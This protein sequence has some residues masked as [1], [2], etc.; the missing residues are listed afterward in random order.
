MLIYAQGGRLGNDLGGVVI[1]S[2]FVDQGLVETG[3]R[4]CLV[5]FRGDLHVIG[6]Y[7][8]P[9][10]RF[11][12]DEG[13]WRISG[14]RPPSARLAVSVGAGTGGSDGLCLAAIKFLHK[15]GSI[16]LAES[17]FGNVVNVGE[18]GGA[19]RSWSGIDAASGE[20]RVTHVRG[21]VS[22]D[23]AE[24]R[25]AWE[26]PYGI[27]AY[28][29]NV[30]T[31][32]LTY[33][34]KG[35]DHGLVPETRF[36][37]EW[38]G[39]MWYASAPKHPYRI[40]YSMAGNPQYV[41]PAA[42]RDTLG[43]EEITGIAKGRNELIV[44]C[45]RNS[46]MIRQFGS[47]VNDF[48]MEKLDS[49]V[50]CIS[51]FG[52]LE[53]HNKLWFPS[54]DGVWLYDGGFRYLMREVQP[55]WRS[56]WNSNKEDFLA[57]FAL[58]DRINKV[59]LWVTRRP[60]REEFENTGLAPGTV[61]Y[62]GYY[63]AFEPSMAG[64]QGHPEWSLDMKY[65][66]DSAGFYDTDGNLVI[67]SCDGKI[68]KQDWTDG[69]DDDDLLR[70]ELL[71]RSGHQ[72]FFEPGDDRESGKQVTQLWFYV[73]SELTSWSLYVRGGDEEAWRSALPDNDLSFWKISV[74]DSRKEE[75]R[76]IRRARS[77]KQ[78]LRFL[79][80]PATVH[81]FVPEQCVG[82]G[83]TFETRAVAPIGLEYRGFGGVWLPGATA[84]GV[85]QMTNLSASV[86]IHG[87]GGNASADLEDDPV[88]IGADLHE[89]VT[90]DPTVTLVYNY[91]SA[92]WPITLRL[93]GTGDQAIDD[94]LVLQTPNLTGS[95]ATIS[96]L[97]NE[98]INLSLQL[99][100]AAGVSLAEPVVGTVT[101]VIP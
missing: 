74:T 26:A 98:T 18:L 39:R 21:Y 75:T 32:Q 30:R 46:Y 70:K 38:Q 73:K 60:D 67:G 36:G 92:V 15:A 1:P 101:C 71:I 5:W 96:Q 56:D 80:V 100:D 86:E 93:V 76:T 27:T 44:F 50:G 41:A 53:I 13:G 9:V 68:R 64:D 72:L 47:G 45:L 58:H 69:D 43:K 91:G 22:V 12:Q 63:G 61:A 29:E 65:R 52:I 33:A 25:M 37:A 19:G 85:E 81:H 34:T 11:R 49:D 51:H 88:L 4:P 6:Y 31:P 54:E 78:T 16:V 7:T 83:F 82:R 99:V 66:F 14:I 87:S 35:Y 28:V 79:Y 2:F 3:R 55:L 40:W 57:G 42:F 23:G 89:A 95:F 97:P 62:V 17:N 77:S 48:I 24:F 90:Y 20:S 8:R 59:Y 10:I 84:R 94:E